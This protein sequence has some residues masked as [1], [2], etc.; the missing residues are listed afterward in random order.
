MASK[1]CITCGLCRLHGYNSP[2]CT[3][4]R[5]YVWASGSCSHWQKEK[6]R[7]VPP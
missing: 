4:L 3:F 5:A 1:T 6:P 7:V 2:W